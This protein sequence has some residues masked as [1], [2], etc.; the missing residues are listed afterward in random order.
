MGAIIQTMLDVLVKVVDAVPALKGYRTVIL[1][2]IML[3][4]ALLDQFG[5]GPGG[6]FE[7]A[8]PY[9]IGATM[10]TALAHKSKAA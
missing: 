3:V 2:A 5:V 1:V 6:L 9:L 10:L 8:K 4:L 7:M